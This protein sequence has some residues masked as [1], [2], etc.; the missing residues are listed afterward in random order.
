MFEG[1]KTDLALWMLYLIKT[2]QVE[3]NQEF[4]EG[5]EKW[6]KAEMESII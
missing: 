2:K 4:L 5:F 6:R 1:L 3:I